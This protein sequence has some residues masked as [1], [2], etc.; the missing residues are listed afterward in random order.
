MSLDTHGEGGRFQPADLE[1]AHA[2]HVEAYRALARTIPGA[3]IQE[4]SDATYLRTELPAQDFNSVF[5]ARRPGNPDRIVDRAKRFFDG[6]KG[7]RKIIS[8]PEAAEAVRPAAEHLH[9][10]LDE[11]L[12]LMILD[13]LDRP[14]IP[15]P[16]GLSLDQVEDAET[17]R[18]YFMTGAQGYGAPREAFAPLTEN[19]D[20]LARVLETPGWTNYLA[21]IGR[22]PVATVL[23]FTS[24]RVAGIY[25]VS[26]L[27]EYRRRGIGGA[28]TLRA[29]LEGNQE[30]CTIS[31]L[32]SSKMGFP[33]Y[34]R[35]G[36]RVAFNYAQWGSSGIQSREDVS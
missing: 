31:G 15:L 32:Q 4:D 33:V 29:A 9:L 23:R 35:I 18:T 6:W 30:G 28:I 26:T 34:Q 27:P 12:P 14:A 17:L 19:E 1:R 2:N 20:A 7:P 25:F 8:T 5:V 22:L 36:Y 21:S 10:T 3:R 16:K 11:G 13:P 24:H